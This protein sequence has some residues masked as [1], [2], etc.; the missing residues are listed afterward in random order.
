MDGV[1][2]ERNSQEMV[3]LK[4]GKDREAGELSKIKANAD[5]IS[6]KNPYG[7]T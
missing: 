6:S 4:F 7:Q 3:E 1:K 5:C 2:S